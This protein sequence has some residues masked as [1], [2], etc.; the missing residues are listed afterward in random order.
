MKNAFLKMAACLCAKG[1]ALLVALVLVMATTWVGWGNAQDAPESTS[2]EPAR[3]A[4]IS[5]PST[6]SGSALQDLPEEWEQAWRSPSVADRPLQILHAKFGSGEETIRQRVEGLRT[7]GLGG[8]VV[9]V[10]G[11]RYLET[12]EAWEDLAL[13]VK[14]MK[15]AGLRVWIYD[16][17]GYPSPMAGGLILRDRPELEA[18]EL[19]YDAATGEFTVRPCFEYTHAANNFACVRRYPSLVNPEVGREFLAKTHEA[20][21]RHLGP[22][23]FAHVE[24][25][26]TDEP[27]S[28]AMNTGV[29]NVDK[30]RLNRVDDEDL[31]KPNLPMVVWAEDFPEI[32]QQRYG[33]DLLAVRRSLFEGDSDAD[34]LVRERF[35][36]MV[37][38]REID[39]YYAPL[40]RWCQANGKAFS[41]HTLCE[42]E[43]YTYPPLDGDKLAVLKQ[44]GIPG[45]DMLNS[46]PLGV[47]EFYWR[48]AVLPS[49]AAI[50]K[51]TRRIFSEVSDFEQRNQAQPFHASLPW[52]RATAG[53]HAAFGVTDYTLYYAPGK[54]TPEEYQ[55]Y[56]TFVGRLNAIL[57]EAQQVRHV[58]LYYPIR[59]W[60]ENCIPQKDRPNFDTQ[61]PKGR[62]V[63]GSWYYC[64]SDLVK[65]QIPFY[66]A[67]QDDLLRMLALPQ[68]AP[69]RPQWVVLPAGVTLSEEERNAL[70]DFEKNGGAVITHLEGQH[71]PNEAFPA[72]L[73]PSCGTIVR[74]E[75]QRDGHTIQLLVNVGG[76]CYT[77]LLKTVKPGE[78]LILDP[79]SGSVGRKTA[80]EEGLEFTLDCCQTLL[81]VQ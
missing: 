21:K 66:A 29:L 80:T 38:Q 47:L 6:P 8:A 64:G 67:S 32:Y 51:G 56:C 35:W 49:S 48:T 1:F 2:T 57:R 43:P 19:V 73:K 71:L 25:F 3:P 76:E 9:N 54:R 30:S 78:C 11:A 16:E 5:G 72:V 24:A 63:T 58:L 68:G 53:W 34:R 59:D 62:Q 36:K 50:L 81:I 77:G 20:Y 70:N 37:A 60:Q 39:S 33:Q 12:P 55:A 69:C 17:Q 74:G 61:L 14:A 23:L 7:L 45:L 79:P 28:N 4:A 31:S 18:Q 27:S 44:F 52:M 13:F 15:E 40:D 41:G 22:D 42:E 46:W 10:G 75:F 26:F 65:A